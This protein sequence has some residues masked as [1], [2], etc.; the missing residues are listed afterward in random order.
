MRLL[1]YKMEP[2]LLRKDIIMKKLVAIILTLFMLIAMLSGCGTGS[3]SDETGKIPG[4]T[5]DAGADT[6]RVENGENDAT[7]GAG[8]S[9][10]SITED[11]TEGKNE[12]ESDETCKHLLCWYGN[13]P[14]FR[15][16]YSQSPQT[17]RHKTLSP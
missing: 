10:G 14:P 12:G 8:N 6:E 4:T 17:R 11:K 3:S 5:G 15:P 9:Q 1:L 13:Q 16:R 7:G 2:Y